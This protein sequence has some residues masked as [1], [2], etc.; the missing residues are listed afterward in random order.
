[1][2]AEMT[3]LTVAVRMPAAMADA[4][5]ALAIL[6]ARHARTAVHFLDVPGAD[7]QRLSL[8]A[9]LFIVEPP[10]ADLDRLA[11]E[12]KRVLAA[13][14]GRRPAM[15]LLVAADASLEAALRGRGVGPYVDGF[16][17]P[18]EPLT[19]AADLLAPADG[20]AA[21]VRRLP[22][23]GAAAASIVGV[24]ARLAS[25][26]PAG[27]VAVPE[28]PLHCAGRPIAA[29]LN[30]GTLDLVA[31]SRACPVPA[32]VTGD[33]AGVVADRIDAGDASAFR[34]R[35]AGGDRFAEG[36]TVGAARALTVDEIV[37]RH[38]A[39]AARQAAA[40]RTD[41]AT[42]TQT[43]TLELPGFVAPVSITARTTIFRDR[44]QVDLRQADI[45][46]NGVP[47]SPKNGVPRL[48]IVEPQ[49]VA[50]LP[51]AITLTGVYRY[52]LAGRES[53]D[54][55]PCYVIAFSPR[56]RGTSLFTG[57]AW[58]DEATFGMIRVSAAQTDL[59]GPIVA[60]EQTDTFV[61]D[62][63]GLWLLARSDI[64]QTYDGAA[65]RTPIH[66]VLEIDGHQIDAP[67]FTA[68]RDA[69]Y[70][71]RDVILRDTPDGF[72][73]LER[74]AGSGEPEAGGRKP[75]AGSREPKAEGGRTVAP[76]VTSLRTFA[77]G[78][79]VDPDISTPL[80]F[81]GLSYLDFD[82]FHTGTQFN[83]FFGG[84]Y[85]QAAFS[86]PSVAG[87]RWQIA[88]R[89]F[90]IAAAYHDRAFVEG[91]EI[92]ARD[93]EQRPAQASVWALRPIAPRA[94]VRF[95]YDWDYNR[96]AR[97]AETDPAFVLPHSQNA[98]TLRAGI[99]VQR[100]GWQASLWAS[101][102][103]RVGW[104]RW[105]VPGTDEDA[106]PR[107]S[108]QR[109]GASV[110]RTTAV[111]PRLTTRIE[112]SIV[113]GRDL[114]RFSRM[115]FGAFDNRL[116]GYPSALIRY[117]R[118]AVLRSAISWAAAR[119]VRIDGFADTA[120]VHDP[121]FGPGLRNETGFGAALECP[122]PFGTLLSV[123]WGYGVQGVN[124]NGTTGTHVLR[125]TGYKVF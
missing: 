102:T 13:A 81:A 64:R 113:G 65:I 61:P 95:E 12:L 109:A 3:G 25:W 100:R 74:T 88:G 32:V 20:R 58:I 91:R 30:P 52:A 77:A 53:I 114:D 125:I 70:A 6:Q 122:A 117:D 72:R 71:S 1:M 11:F 85:A 112:G 82:L 97:A 73:Y 107:P 38:Q 34:I 106:S 75:E 26:F 45:R 80:P 87:S 49:R 93:I 47:I 59:N 16:V 41:V 42:G 31:A 83:G 89:A 23:A 5:P 2:P 29:F 119:A 94:L 69:A 121:A 43:L 120:A 108:F 44:E 96:F 55:R 40:V 33:A 90:A 104:E 17:S 84:S 28:R 24:A 63:G 98:H 22:D 124:T 10:A 48:P 103:R 19:S 36:V 51:L 79:I 57:R 99:D 115:S 116:H 15:G 54:G 101:H 92:Y 50:V 68:R 8:D 35:G 9:D 62:A 118:G 56:Q 18:S 86:A 110:V 4:R 66:R 105:G 76:P 60:S 27:L 37:A 78:V 39:A 7:D 14:R 67:D 46:V 21:V 123:E 111:S